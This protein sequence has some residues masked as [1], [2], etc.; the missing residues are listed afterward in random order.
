MHHELRLARTCGRDGVFLKHTKEF[1][2]SI[3]LRRMSGKPFVEREAMSTEPK[4]RIVAKL[5]P[6]VSTVNGTEKKLINTLRESMKVRGGGN[7]VSDSQL[8]GT[9]VGTDD[10]VHALKAPPAHERVKRWILFSDLHVKLSSIETCE[11]V[12]DIVNIEACRREAGVIFLGD[13]WHVRGALNVAL[14]NRVMRSL[15]KWEV[16]VIMI[17]GNHDQVTLGGMVHSLEPLQYAFSKD[18]I[19]MISEP[20]VCLGALWI[21]YRRDHQLM[22]SILSNA[23]DRQDFNAIFCHADVK[24]AFMNDGMR[25]RDGISIR[26][27][28]SGKLVYSGHFHKPHTMRAGESCLR[29]LGSPYQTSL[30]E[31][32]QQKFLYCLSAFSSSFPKK[33]FWVEEERWP[34]DVGRKFYKAVSFEDPILENVKCGDRVVVEVN[35]S[36]VYCEAFEKLKSKG[37]EIE[38]RMPTRSPMIS[39]D[40]AS[41]YLGDSDGGSVSTDDNSKSTRE[42]KHLFDEFMNLNSV[43]LS[44]EKS[45]PTSGGTVDTKNLKN[46]HEMIIEEGK[47][48]IDR[49]LIQDSTSTAATSGGLSSHFVD[50]NKMRN[51]RLDR[52]TLKNFGPYGGTEI[53]Y[54]LSNR[55]LVLLRG[56]SSDGTGADSNGAGKTT[57]AMSVMWA[58]I[59]SMDAR[60]VADGRAVDVA[61]D[62]TRGSRDKKRIAEVILEG[63]INSSPFRIERRRGAK[64]VELNFVVDEVDHTQQSVKDTQAIIDDILGVGGGLLQRCCFYGQHSHTLQSLLGL[65]DVKLKNELSVL[66]DTEL[67]SL[68]LQD[69]KNRDKLG[70][71][72]ISEIGVETRIRGEETERVKESINEAMKRY[73]SL[74]TQYHDAANQLEKDLKKRKCTINNEINSTTILRTIESCK[75]RSTEHRTT[76]LEPLEKNFASF[77]KDHQESVAHIDDALLPLEGKL[78]IAQT[79]LSSI[80]NMCQYNMK[81]REDIDKNITKIISEINN[82]TRS[83][84]DMLGLPEYR[85]LVFPLCEGDIE[86]ISILTTDGMQT[87]ADQY[88]SVLRIYATLESS[89]IEAKES[90][91]AINHSCHEVAYDM[92][93]NCPVCGQPFQEHSKGDRVAKITKKL[94]ELEDEM[95]KVRNKR[96]SHKA[97]LDDL[98]NAKK[99][100]EKL[101]FLRDELHKLDIEID[102]DR[103]KESYFSDESFRLEEQ[104]KELREKKEILKADAEIKD[105]RFLSELRAAQHRNRNYLIELEK[106]HM[107]LDDVRKH[108][109]ESIY[110]RTESNAVIKSLESKLQDSKESISKQSST[111]FE[112]ESKIKNGEKEKEELMNSSIILGE[113]ASIFGP[114]G[115]QHYI[116]LDA[117]REL[118]DIANS[119][120][121]VLADGGI[122]LSLRSDEDADKIVKS[123]LIRSNEGRYRERALSQLSGGQWRRVSMSLDF[124][125]AEV[126]RR[127][128]TLRSNFLVMDEVLTH[129]D[130]SG[131]EAVGTILRALVSGDLNDR[132]KIG[133]LDILT[134]EIHEKTL[135]NYDQELV[136]GLV[137]GGAYETV[138][139]IL[140]DL[141]ATE[142]EEAFDHID[143]VIKEDE[144][145]RV[146]IDGLQ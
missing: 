92:E 138:L 134:H 7:K 96:Q 140:Q 83:Y 101:L 48:T 62:S 105:R 25:S 39:E 4:R 44:I 54:P 106:L 108:E 71:T 112:L 22:Q 64:K 133:N 65:S 113:L 117:L 18:Q 94:N 87:A 33:R 40:I 27:F 53:Q 1:H 52:V 123:I 110:L 60:L 8:I 142:L 116:F 111:L 46:V 80:K 76:I 78:A 100:S 84:H 107:Q 98:R 2:Y 19:L 125:F 66:V 56:Q 127:K 10:L 131:R 139:I 121:N 49:M 103:K 132:S 20:C 141:A 70:K 115:I 13:F 67:W 86:W 118:E 47:N 50:S 55:G 16:P 35:K 26:S 23:L 59:G 21:P 29:Y 41:K 143:V 32:G 17:P 102:S 34:I 95:V 90:I 57:L 69:I 82:Y 36:E 45:I 15:R 144:S 120:L 37:I 14:L 74:E 11:K 122:Q 75:A 42:P 9:T 85:R 12:L 128:G 81:K 97:A 30:S 88:D 31:A 119:Y 109:A 51:L 79:S 104:L 77:R 89:M 3:S 91:C 28:P 129:L 72:R 24:G 5:I 114:R 99:F 63:E 126:I 93:D 135:V 145:S 137:R 58:L 136:H 6:D 43:K 73:R 38:L 68:A 146:E 124:A 61:F 130:A